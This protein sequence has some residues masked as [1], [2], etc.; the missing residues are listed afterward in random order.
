MLS[1]ILR[2][3]SAIKMSIHIMNAFVSMRKFLI[4]NGQLF[5]RLDTIEK[6]HI[7]CKARDHVC[8]YAIFVMKSQGFH[9]IDP[10]DLQ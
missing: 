8:R 3:E 6:R 1:G 10:Y 5:I 7:Q 4:E 9:N 2:S